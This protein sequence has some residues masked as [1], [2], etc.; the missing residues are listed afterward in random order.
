MRL[1]LLVLLCVVSLG[2]IHCLCQESRSRINHD[3]VK[4]AVDRATTKFSN[5]A[6]YLDQQRWI[7]RTVLVTGSFSNY[8]KD[9]FR[10]DRKYE[11]FSGQN[12]TGEP[13]SFI[14][15]YDSLYI[16][17]HTREDSTLSSITG[18][19][20]AWVV[21]RVQKCVEVIAYNGIMKVL[22]VMELM[23]A[24]RNDDYSYSKPRVQ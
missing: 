19:A 12:G 4:A 5:A 17:P 6:M 24:F 1:R 8:R 11:L 21:G 16:K 20:H 9:M 15:L 2:K 3:A 14:V 13:V 22:P 23:L 18:N 7:G 10:T